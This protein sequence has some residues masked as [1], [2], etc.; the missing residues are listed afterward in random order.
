MQ[1]RLLVPAIVMVLASG[2]RDGSP[3]ES[4]AAVDRDAGQVCALLTD[5]EADAAV[6]ATV[7]GHRSNAPDDPRSCSWLQGEQD[8]EAVVLGLAPPFDPVEPPTR[9]LTLGPPCEPGSG[10]TDFSSSQGGPAINATCTVDGLVVLLMARTTELPNV[11]K[12]LQQVVPRLA[13]LD[14][15]AL[16]LPPRPQPGAAPTTRKPA[17]APQECLDAWRADRI[18]PVRCEEY[19][20]AYQAV[21]RERGRP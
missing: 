3:S 16:R 8:R 14:R 10:A 4:P 21:V 7:V 18:A 9:R 19:P 11:V 20:E 13:T 2:C 15:A 1:L 5:G 6:P 12:L 17:A